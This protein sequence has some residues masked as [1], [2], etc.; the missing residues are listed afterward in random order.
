[1]VKIFCTKKLAENLPVKPGRCQEETDLFDSWYANTTTIGRTTVV[2]AVCGA[3]RFGF[4]LWGIKKSQWKEIPGMILDGIRKTLRAYGVKERLIEEYAPEGVPLE[5][6]AASDRKGTAQSGMVVKLLNS[7]R[8]NRMPSKLLPLPLARSLNL[9]YMHITSGSAT[10]PYE[11]MMKHLEERFGEYPVAVSAFVLNVEM[12]MERF[13]VSR[14]LTVPA[15]ATFEELHRMLQAAMQWQNYHMHDFIIPAEEELHLVATDEGAE[16][17][18][19]QSWKLD[20]TV[21]LDDYLK[22]G[23]RFLYRY[24]FGDGWEVLIEVKDFRTDYDR[25]EPSCSKC[26]G[27]APPED[28][29]GVDGYLHFLDAMSDE[30]HPEHD[31]LKEWVGYRWSAEPN[32]R[33]INSNLRYVL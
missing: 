15:S 4:V 19:G 8:F 27:A 12:D 14:T 31:E 11:E 30:N 24:D 20:S 13:V 22:P 2:A 21:T 5:V 29:G 10:T 7:A 1:M 16:E 18:Y 25:Y 3:N 28:V 9:D 6:Y 23:M 17:L 26:D 33:V 32:I